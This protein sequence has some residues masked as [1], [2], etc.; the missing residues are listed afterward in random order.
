M[1]KNRP[2]MVNKDPKLRMSA[3]VLFFI[4]NTPAILFGALSSSLIMFWKINH[5][6]II[7]ESINST[8]PK[9]S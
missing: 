9:D 6:K 7:I 4:V 2:I 5:K 8:G 3:L 1:K